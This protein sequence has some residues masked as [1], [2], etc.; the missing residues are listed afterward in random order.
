M[1]G[2]HPFTWLALKELSTRCSS[3]SISFIHVIKKTL[4]EPVLLVMCCFV[5]FF[6]QV[7]SKWGLSLLHAC[8][9]I[10]NWKNCWKKTMNLKKR[11][12]V[13]LNQMTQDVSRR[14]RKNVQ[15]VV[16]T[17]HKPPFPTLHAL[18]DVKFL[19]NN[20][21][22]NYYTRKPGLLWLVAGFYCQR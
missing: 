2:A 21:K 18:S 19:L 6:R 12:V 1:F 11:Q 20:P 7:W 10:S 8:E 4:D 16:F 5:L 3:I 9:V 22:A 17:I 13:V 14:Q 15:W